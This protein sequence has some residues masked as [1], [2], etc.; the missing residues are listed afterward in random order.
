MNYYLIGWYTNTQEPLPFREGVA[1]VK[2]VNLYEAK[3][4]LIQ[5]K[6]KELQDKVED[7]LGSDVLMVDENAIA[8]I[9]PDKFE[10]NIATVINDVE[11]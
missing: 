7:T 6:T 8:E 4:V 3:K 2:A 10:D 1:L 9:T 11:W 5:I